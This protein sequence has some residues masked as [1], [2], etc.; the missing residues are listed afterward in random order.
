MVSSIATR[1]IVHLFLSADLFLVTLANMISILQ[2][3]RLHRRRAN[4]NH[5]SLAGMA[6]E[7]KNAH[8]ENKKNSC[9][10]IN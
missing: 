8:G 3:R 2:E 10:N 1:F 6:A 7:K 9:V 4:R 5:F